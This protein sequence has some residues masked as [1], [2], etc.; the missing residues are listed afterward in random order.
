MSP[1][2]AHSKALRMLRLGFDTDITPYTLIKPLHHW[3]IRFPPQIFADIT[4]PC[5]SLASVGNVARTPPASRAPQPD[6][7]TPAD[8]K[9]Y[10]V[11]VKGY[12][13]E[14][15][16]HDADVKGYDKDVKGYG[17]EVK[18]Y[19]VDVKGYSCAALIANTLKWVNR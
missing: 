12:S 17:A 2:S 1:R 9:G 15:K 19:D 4:C 7:R 6:E 13:A 18:G 14:I 11:D 3:R 8:V 10:G 16:G 5:R